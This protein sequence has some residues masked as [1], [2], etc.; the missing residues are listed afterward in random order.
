MPTRWNRSKTL[1]RSQP[2]WSTGGYWTGRP[3]ID[4]WLRLK[5]RSTISDLGG[6]LSA[7]VRG[8]AY[9]CA[10]D[11][12]TGGAFL[13]WA[14]ATSD[15][16]Y[17]SRR[18]LLPFFSGP[19]AKTIMSA[20]IVTPSKIARAHPYPKRSRRAYSIELAGEPK[21]TPSWYTRPGNRLRTES[22]ESSLRWIGITPQA[23]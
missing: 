18:K 3:S 14:A 9:N 2:S 22:G 8:L 4:S 10:P 21:R 20:T 12:G 6:N 15:V 19:R 5:L 17:C 11:A 16:L 13:A 1:E 23:P 7:P